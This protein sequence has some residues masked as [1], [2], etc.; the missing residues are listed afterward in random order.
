[1]L[2]DLKLPPLAAAHANVFGLNAGARLN[3][4]SAGS[5]AYLV[6][7]ASAQRAAAA[8]LNRAIPS[9]RI[10]YRYRV[11]LDGFA[12]SLPARELPAKRR[13]RSANGQRHL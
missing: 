11:I 4:R 5:H 12:L 6:R 3:V 13:A 7:L 8:Q 9:A 10:S 2:V 1:M